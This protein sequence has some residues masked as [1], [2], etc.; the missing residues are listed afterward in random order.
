M[1]TFEV[2]VRIQG[3]LR[4]WEEIPFSAHT[5]ETATSEQ[6]VKLAS[7]VAQEIANNTPG[8]VEVRWNWQGSLQGHYIQPK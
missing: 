5:C 4:H 7:V 2:R 1:E 3:D 6:Q 8:C